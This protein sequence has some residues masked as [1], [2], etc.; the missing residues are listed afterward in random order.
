VTGTMKS[1]KLY[2]AIDLARDLPTSAR[3]VAAQ[4]HSSLGPRMALEDYLAFLASI[5][6]TPV[7]GI[8]EK[9]VP[10]GVAPFELSR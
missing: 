7:A 8:G 4:R 9:A 10:R 5:P 2:P 1:G 6:P 3:D